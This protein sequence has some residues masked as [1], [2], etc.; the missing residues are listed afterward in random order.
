MQLHN[1]GF[2]IINPSLFDP[3]GQCPRNKLHCTLQ[4]YENRTNEKTEDQGVVIPY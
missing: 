1:L 4:T 3:I 2:V